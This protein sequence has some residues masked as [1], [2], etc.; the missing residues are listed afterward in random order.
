MGIH[1]S[2]LTWTRCRAAGKLLILRLRVY[3]CVFRRG[4]VCMCL[5]EVECVCVCRGDVFKLT[6][7][8]GSA[9][10]THSTRWTTPLVE[11]LKVS[12]GASSTPKGTKSS[13][14]KVIPVT[15]CSN[16]CFTEKSHRHFSGVSKALTALQTRLACPVSLSWIHQTQNN[17][18]FFIP[19]ICHY[20]S[21]KSIPNESN[22]K[23]L[24]FFF[25]GGVGN[26]LH[27]DKNS[28]PLSLQFPKHTMWWKTRK[29]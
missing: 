1:V 18:R 17:F 22:S 29:Y 5:G 25:G 23:E 19:V 26:S 6:D 12:T 24:M 3:V 9:L 10:K 11:Q 21:K 28:Q 27:K 14:P 16:S 20:M 4:G 2:A 8:T 7:T 15:R 13:A